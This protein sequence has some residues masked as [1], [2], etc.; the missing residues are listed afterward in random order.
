MKRLIGR[1]PRR[2]IARLTE[3][4]GG[5]L[6]TA[7][8]CAV[9]WIL[10]WH[11]AAVKLASPLLLPA[12]L[13]V[14]R[15]IGELAK[16]ADFWLFSM[17]SLA[18]IL[19]GILIGIVL[20]SL[21]AI[22]TAISDAAHL[23]LSPIITVVKSTPVASFIILAMLWINED[24]LPVFIS[25]LIV[26]PVLWSNLHTAFRGIPQPYH[27]VARV[28]RLPLGRRIRRIYLPSALPYFISACRSCLG[29]AWKAGIAAEAIALPAVSIGKQL[30][31][32][33]IYL[34]TTDMFAWTTVV[35]LLSLLLE[36]LAELI[37][38]PLQ[39][40]TAHLTQSA[41]DQSEQRRT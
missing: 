7:L 15:R 21:A 18:R 28:F 1:N 24:I 10:I 36:C 26:F 8:V 16:T 6:F 12:P 40:K 41:Q 29:L 9:L 31:D 19:G 2:S 11:L 35:I 27:D 5:R 22:L 38:R 23:L 17:L 34:E 30:M 39:R 20:A 3:K 13:M 37:F 25:F 4:R 33:K 32:A 14:F